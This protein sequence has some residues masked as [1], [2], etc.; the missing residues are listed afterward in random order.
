MKPFFGYLN[1]VRPHHNTIKEIIN[2]IL[3]NNMIGHDDI[4]SMTMFVFD[5]ETV[6]LTGITATKLCIAYITTERK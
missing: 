6:T 5:L 4:A 3:N 1:I 2:S